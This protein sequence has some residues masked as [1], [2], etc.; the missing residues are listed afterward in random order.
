ME[1]LRVVVSLLCYA[2]TAVFFWKSRDKV[3]SHSLSNGENYIKSEGL[4]IPAISGYYSIMVFVSPHVT[5]DENL[6]SL[7]R[8]K[9]GKHNS[10][11]LDE[12]GCKKDGYRF[13]PFKE[14]KNLYALPRL[15]PREIGCEGLSIEISKENKDI[16]VFH[17]GKNKMVDFH[18][19]KDKYEEMVSKLAEGEELAPTF[20]E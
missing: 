4:L 6:E 12:N 18:L 13:L 1:D 17:F 14:N 19:I 7:E 10:E 9:Y 16:V 15:Y 3:T 5:Y 11:C 2:A 8:K 20:D